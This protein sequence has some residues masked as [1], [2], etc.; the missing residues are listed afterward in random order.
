MTS[1]KVDG[2]E[3]FK[4][5]LKQLQTGF[6]IGGPI[7]QN[8]I[9]FFVNFEI[10]NRSN[11]G[12]F[13]V[14]NAGTSGDNVLRVLQADMDLV[15]NLL[16]T[17]YG[18]DTGAT[19]DF[20][21]DSDNRK[22]IV[23]LDVNLSQNHTLSASYNFLNSFRD[24]PAHPSGIGRRGPDFLTLQFENTG[25]RINNKIHSGIVELK[26]I[27][28]NKISNKAQIGFTAFRD[29]RDAFSSP[30]PMVNI[31][32]GGIQYIIAGHKPF[33]VHNILDQNV[34]QF[35]D[36]V[37][38]LEGGRY[39]YTYS[40]DINN[41][42]S[43]W[44]DLLYIPTDVEINQITFAN[45]AQRVGLKNYMAQDDYLSG[46]RGQYTEKYG[47]LAPWFS[48][49]DLRILQDIQVAG[50]NVFQISLDILNIGNLINSSRVVRQ[51]ATMTSLVQP[52][53]VSVSDGISGYTF[54]NSQTQT[55]FN[56]FSLNSRWQMQLGL[57]YSF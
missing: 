44:N 23:K 35:R 20:I 22:G 38:Y 27:L 14:P 57:R 26:S 52:I 49:A 12:S 11:L 51:F 7:V 10:E 21:H 48:T 16:S 17:K 37:E 39:S 8:K 53:G 43:V 9:F 42:G 54:D 19:R 32:K 30:F 13:F 3:I 2:Q 18:Y 47:A 31:S 6:S 33:S 24:L 40:G 29:D 55:F 5:D 50:D 4:G 36:V 15:S 34:F 25:Y 1:G 56:G 45:D 41:D 28:S 46:R